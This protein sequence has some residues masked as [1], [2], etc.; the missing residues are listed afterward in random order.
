MYSG[1]L[2][3]VNVLEF[4]TP[5]TPNTT[6]ICSPTKVNAVVTPAS[7]EEMQKHAFSKVHETAPTF[8]SHKECSD[9]KYKR[10]YS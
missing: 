4:R 2:G 1:A 7:A 10:F 3:Q 5:E 6:P 8:L 9:G